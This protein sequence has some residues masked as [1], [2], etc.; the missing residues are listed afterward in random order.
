MKQEERNK[1]YE[2]VKATGYIE[3]LNLSRLM[4]EHSLKEMKEE[5]C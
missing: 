4:E 2:M 3:S 1:L 5:V